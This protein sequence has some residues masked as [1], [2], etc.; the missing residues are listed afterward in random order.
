MIWLAMLG[1]MA[2]ALAM[3]SD[4]GAMTSRLMAASTAVSNEPIAASHVSG[5]AMAAFELSLPDR[6]AAWALLPL[7]ALVLWIGA[8][9]MGCL[10]DWS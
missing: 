3:V 6:R 5:A 4:M 7:P 2:V 9:G 8:S 10:R 1:A